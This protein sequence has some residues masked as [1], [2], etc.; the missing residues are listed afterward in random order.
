MQSV[1]R[2][3]EA[4]GLK[5]WLKLEAFSSDPQALLKASAW[6]LRNKQNELRPVIPELI[7]N[8]GG[9]LVAKLQGIDDRSAAELL[10]HQQIEVSRS[11]FPEPASDEYYWADLIGC[12]VWNGGKKLGMVD[13]LIDNGAHSV[14]QVK[15]SSASEEKPRFELIPFVAAYVGEVNLAGKRIEVNWQLD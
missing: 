1:G 13:D 8:Q 9:G 15:L 11:E 7:K 4:Y 2:I 6:W 14:L 12:E 3:S 5:G 10:K